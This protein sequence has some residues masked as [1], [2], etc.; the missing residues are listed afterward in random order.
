MDAE[1]QG[2]GGFPLVSE[3]KGGVSSELLIGDA[4]HAKMEDLFAATT[5]KGFEHGSDAKGYVSYL[6]G[7]VEN[8]PFAALLYL[9]NGSHASVT[10]RMPGT[11]RSTLWV[12]RTVVH[13]GEATG[14]FEPWAG[15]DI[16][17]ESENPKRWG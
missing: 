2:S 3:H 10:G 8:G 6:H 7:E 11:D 12:G 16:P 5:D 17:L 1:E 13:V 9:W 14:S 15:Q 4:V